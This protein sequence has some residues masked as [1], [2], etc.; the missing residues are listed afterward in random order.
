MIYLLGQI[1]CM[2]YIILYMYISVSGEEGLDPL[3]HP[4]KYATRP[5]RS[6][7]QFI[8]FSRL[9]I[10]HNRLPS[11]VFYL[12]LNSLPDCA[13]YSFETVHDVRYSIMYF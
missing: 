13:R 7:A 6:R 2:H 8:Y 3:D 9:K 10:N 4:R 1:L 12:E 11:R 5:R